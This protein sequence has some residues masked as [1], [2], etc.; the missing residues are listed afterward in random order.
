MRERNCA[1]VH[2]GALNHGKSAKKVL[3]GK[4]EA[5]QAWRPGKRIRSQPRHAPATY[6]RHRRFSLASAAAF[7]H[8]RGGTE[9]Q[10]SSGTAPKRYENRF[11]GLALPAFAHMENKVYRDDHGRTISMAEQAGV[12]RRKL[13]NASAQHMVF[14]FLR[15]F[16]RRDKE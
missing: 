2:A 5:P 16:S 4:R 7:N 15:F 12:P 1:A 11:C 10:R 8:T 9:Q 13:S 6:A 3:N 14:A